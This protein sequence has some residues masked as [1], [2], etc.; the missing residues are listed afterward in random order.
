[1]VTGVSSVFPETGVLPFAHARAQ[2]LDIE[3]GVADS[4]NRPILT[5]LAMKTFT[6]FG[7]GVSSLKIFSVVPFL[8]CIL[9]F[10]FLLVGRRG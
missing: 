3:A 6:L 1:M 9:L 2:V 10:G 5:M 8:L 7:I 4:A